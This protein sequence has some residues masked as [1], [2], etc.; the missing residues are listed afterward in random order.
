MK[1]SLSVR[2]DSA[3][4]QAPINLCNVALHSLLPLQDDGVAVHVGLSRTG[5]FA[6]PPAVRDRVLHADEELGHA[7]DAVYGTG[8]GKGRG[9]LVGIVLRS[10]RA[11]GAGGHPLASS[12]RVPGVSPTCSW[13]CA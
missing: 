2:H 12:Q 3:C 5:S 4:R 13:S 8:D 10:R 9:G 6:V 7:C 11:A 1:R